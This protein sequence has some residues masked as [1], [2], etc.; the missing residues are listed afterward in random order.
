[1]LTLPL[2]PGERYVLPD[3]SVEIATENA[4]WVNVDG[5]L[6][7]PLTGEQ[8]TSGSA[9][10]LRDL[11]FPFEYTVRN[12]DTWIS[13]TDLFGVPWVDIQEANPGVTIDLLLGQKLWID[14]AE[15]AAVVGHVHAERMVEYAQDAA[16]CAEPWQLWQRQKGTE[17]VPCRG[18]PA[19]NPKTQYR[20]APVPAP[21]IRIGEIDVPEPLRVAPATGTRVYIP[22]LG[23]EKFSEGIIFDPEDDT[24]AMWLRRGWLHLTREAAETH[25]RALIAVSGGAV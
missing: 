24:C 6:Y 13:V 17:W 23:D 9:V 14:R 21:T 18:N 10:E 11:E 1:M 19:W 25:A 5:R 16:Q 3:G 22:M 4:P 15:P 12:G 20:R 8:I 2:K 7:H